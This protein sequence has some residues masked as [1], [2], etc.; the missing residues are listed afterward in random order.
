M[1]ASISREDSK[2]EEKEVFF[3]LLVPTTWLRYM[4]EERTLPVCRSS[5]EDFV[6]GR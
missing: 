5:L 6:G 2:E 3:A 1:L 4:E